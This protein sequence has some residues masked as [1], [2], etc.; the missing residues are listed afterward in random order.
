MSKKTKKSMSSIYFQSLILGAMIIIREND[1]LSNVSTV[2]PVYRS[3]LYS[4]Q[5]S[6]VIAS[7]LQIIKVQ[8]Y[9][10]FIPK[11]ASVFVCLFVF[12]ASPTSR[13]KVVCW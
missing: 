4:P 11:P 7:I 12:T 8:Q 6:T 10:I 13:R 2:P 1:D 9:R 5:E 3:S